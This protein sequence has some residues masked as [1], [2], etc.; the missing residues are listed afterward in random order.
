M[1]L[2]PSVG[3]YGIEQG[4]AFDRGAAYVVQPRI[5]ADGAS[6]NLGAIMDAISYG[7]SRSSYGISVMLPP[8]DIGLSGPIVIPDGKSIA[9]I[10]AGMPLM[11][12][13]LSGTRLKAL[14][15]TPLIDA[16]GSSA[17]PVASRVMGVTLERLGFWGNGSA[18]DL[19]KAKWISYLHVLWCHGANTTGRYV[20]FDEAWDCHI[21]GGH[22]TFCG[23][24]GNN[25][26]VIEITGPGG[27][28]NSNQIFIDKWRAESCPNTV[29]RTSGN[30]TNEIWLAD[31][32]MENPS[33]QRPMIDLANTTNV[34]LGNVQMTG[35]G[36]TS[37][38]ISSFLKAVGSK[39]ITGRLSIE[40]AGS[41]NPSIT[42]YVD[43]GTSDDIDLGLWLYGNVKEPT[44][45]NIVTHDGVGNVRV[46]GS[47]GGLSAAWG[48]DDPSVGLR[49]AKAVS[50]AVSPPVPS[51]SHTRRE[52]ATRVNL[53]NFSY[54][55]AGGSVMHQSRIRHRLAAGGGNKTNIQLRYAGFFFQAG[56][57]GDLAAPVNKSDLKVAIEYPPGQINPVTFAA[58]SS[59]SLTGGSTVL[60]SD[61][62]ID[63]LTGLPLVA[64]AGAVLYEQ[65]SYVQ[66]SNV[67]VA[68]QEVW[69]SLGEYSHFGDNTMVD[70]S[71]IATG[72]AGALALA[73][74][75]QAWGACSIIAD[76]V[77]AQPAVVIVG[78]SIATGN[79]GDNS[80]VQIEA[81]GYVARALGNTFGWMRMTCPQA[82]I[83]SAINAAWC[84]SLLSNHRVTHA[85]CQMGI[86]NV[87]AGESAELIKSKLL[88]EWLL[89]YNAGIKVWQC[90]LTPITSGTYTTLNG[91][92]A[93][94]NDA[95]RLA[96]NAWIRTRPWPLSG[97]FDVAAKVE[98][99][100]KWAA[101]D[102][103][104]NVITNP[105]TA[106]TAT[107]QDGVHPT[108]D[109]HAKLA[110]GIDTALIT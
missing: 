18:N 42:T 98:I 110:T 10:G 103:S 65:N 2:K 8:G 30:Q 73:S 95:I 71:Q 89:L 55:A 4:D 84:R 38:T 32:K 44:S 23:H 35:G 36:T 70:K 46:S 85:I 26:P 57:A 88:N 48:V 107:A 105:A 77:T 50:I 1:R 54:T 53:R 6:D 69:P 66:A 51:P 25:V 31:V 91:Q 52:A 22:A 63:S 47:K 83:S 97:V 72:Q 43:I 33:T 20:H 79:G 40:L 15:S 39:L 106:G 56:A 3:P 61:V 59:A 13:P 92:T 21:I 101:L 58:A 27:G 19:I 64:P 14:G 93:H 7:L 94:A 104:G 90:T 29:L 78:D 49:R 76:S 99:S 17:S 16:Q 109:G 86:N 34:T 41:A 96:V 45:G 100:S 5:K 108:P 80:A 62:V 9:I 37:A 75:G 60:V 102:G 24:A 68:P 28:A 67:F 81:A 12:T 74:T 11:Q 82:S 87:L